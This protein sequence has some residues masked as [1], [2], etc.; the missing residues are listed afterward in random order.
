MPENILVVAHEPADAER[1]RDYLA[2][3][4][5]VPSFVADGNEALRVIERDH[6][7]LVVVTDASITRLIHDRFPQTPIL[8]M[9]AGEGSSEF[10]RKVQHLLSGHPEYTIRHADLPKI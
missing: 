3:Q 10:L 8:P 9:T 6:P 4:P 5:V 2:G 7:R 1:V